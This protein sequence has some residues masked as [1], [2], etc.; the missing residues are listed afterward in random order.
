MFAGTFRYW[1]RSFFANGR[2]K[3]DRSTALR[4]SGQPASRENDAKPRL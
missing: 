4:R 3:E 2:E 1:K